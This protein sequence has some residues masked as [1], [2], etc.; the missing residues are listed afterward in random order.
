MAIGTQMNIGTRQNL[1][2]SCREQPK[3]LLDPALRFQDGL[4]TKN[5]LLAT[6]AV[7]ATL[8]YYANLF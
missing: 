3:P 7:P 6:Y 8:A 4:V 1:E 5:A 2:F